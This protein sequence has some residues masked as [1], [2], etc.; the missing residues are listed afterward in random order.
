MPYDDPFLDTAQH[1]D[2]F[3]RELADISGLSE[4]NE[5]DVNPNIRAASSLSPFDVDN[6]QVHK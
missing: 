2:Y 1:D 6:K 5:A 3:V 4:N